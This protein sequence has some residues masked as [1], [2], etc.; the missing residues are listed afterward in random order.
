MLAAKIKIVTDKFSY[1]KAKRA[2]LDNIR[3]P[4]VDG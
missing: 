3:T 1:D 4:Y 2:K